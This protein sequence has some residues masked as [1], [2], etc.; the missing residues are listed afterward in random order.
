VAAVKRAYFDLWFNQRAEALLNQNREL[1]EDFLNIARDRY[2]G[3][4]AVQVDVLRAE[5]AVSDIDRELENTHQAISQARA[6]LARL[7]H[8]SP[9]MELM[10]LPESAAT[11]VPAN[12]DRLYQLAIATRPELQGRLAAIA[13]DEKGIELARKRYYPNV[14]VGLLYQDMQKTNAMTPLTA[15]GV[16]NVGFFVG[17]NLPIYRKKLAAGVFEAQARASANAQLYEA[18]RDQVQRDVKDLFT[19]AKVQQN[20]IDLLRRTNL[21]NSQQVLKTTAGEYRAGNVDY[22]SLISAWRE[23][24]QVELQIAQI[25][26]ELGKTIASLERAVGSQ[27][28]EYPPDPVTLTPTE[29][30]GV[31]VPPPPPSESGP[32][33]SLDEPSHLPESVEAPSR[34]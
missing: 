11:A 8:V 20:I 19:Q 22:L 33:R 17:F 30:T 5:T 1:A 2:K 23:V 3:S 4:T 10:T 9:E 29:G 26:A 18:D 7:L 14:T 25:E 34:K 16:P 21:P 24:L 12:I 6:E 13:R 28:N 32:F 15:S 31:T 27:L